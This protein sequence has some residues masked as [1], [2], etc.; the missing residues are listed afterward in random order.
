MIT[1][2]VCQTNYISPVPTYGAPK[3]DCRP[4]SLCQITTSQVLFIV[5]VVATDKTSFYIFCRQFSSWIISHLIFLNLVLDLKINLTIFPPALTLMILLPAVQLVHL[6]TTQLSISRW[7][8]LDLLTNLELVQLV[9]LL[10]AQVNREV[11]G[12]VA[13]EVCNDVPKQQCANVQDQVFST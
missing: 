10:T 13:S 11:C 4:V 1:T 2:E 5:V 6:L 9:D 3:P 7:T 12:P 8:W